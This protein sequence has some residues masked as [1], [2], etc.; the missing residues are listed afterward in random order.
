MPNE[1][2]R[3]TEERPLEDTE[4]RWP[5]TSYG[6]NPQEKPILPHLDL[7]LPASRN[8]RQKNSYC[9][10]FSVCDALLSKS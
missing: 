9:L 3:H 1:R 7:D 4:R 10:S 8:T 5:S 6:K 2:E